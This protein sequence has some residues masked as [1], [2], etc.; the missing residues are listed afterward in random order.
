MKQVHVSKN[1][2][3]SMY[4]VHKKRW[5]GKKRKKNTKLLK[6]YMYQVF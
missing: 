2:I 5:K 4:T 6:A 3:D 1:R